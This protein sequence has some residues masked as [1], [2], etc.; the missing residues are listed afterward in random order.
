MV[1]YIL[2]PAASN[3]FVTELL[4]RYNSCRGDPPKPLISKQIFSP[5]LSFKSSIK[6]GTIL[7]AKASALCIFSLFLPGSP[8]IPTPNSISSGPIS[9]VGEPAAGTVHDVSANPKLLTLSMTFCA[10]AF[11][12]A[13]DA[14]CSAF[15]PAIL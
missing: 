8:C 2:T 6:S 11:T 13:K 10:T 4:N 15:A 5:F 3:S 1:L 9:N 7:F 12:S 14:P